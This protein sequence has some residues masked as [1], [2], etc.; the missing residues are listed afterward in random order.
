M[1]GHA[2]HS[3]GR[4]RLVRMLVSVF[5]ALV[6]RLLSA[7]PVGA[8]TCNAA[9]GPDRW[10]EYGSAVSRGHVV[11][12][13]DRDDSR[14]RREGARVRVIRSWKGSLPEYVDVGVDLPAPIGL[15]GRYYHPGTEYLFY[16]QGEPPT[17]TP[18]L[19]APLLPAGHARDELLYLDYR[20]PPHRPG[21]AAVILGAVA[22]LR[23]LL[24]GVSR[25]A[26]RRRQRLIA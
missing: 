13:Y 12:A 17:L 6:A 21:R 18:L 23:L 16:A 9:V 26:R 20:I 10:R 3:V 22:L 19:C 5:L 2:R 11:E 7:N 8:T 15:G 4:P 25:L 24:D 14:A 1:I